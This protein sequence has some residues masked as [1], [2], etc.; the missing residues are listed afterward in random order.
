MLR[1]TLR[2]AAPGVLL[3]TV[4]LVPFLDKAFTIDDTTLMMMAEHAL[5]EPL[6]PSAIAIAWESDVPKRATGATGALMAWLLVPAAL[7]GGSERLAHGMEL[8][9]LAAGVLGTVALA[10]RL[11]LGP[12]PARA[13]GLLLVSTP[14]VLGLSGTA[15]PDVPAM[16]V[17][18][19]GLERLLAW[20]S[21]RRSSQGI[22]AALLLGLAP[23]LRPNLVLL[24]ALGALCWSE[25]WR[26]PRLGGPCR[27]GAGSFSQPSPLSRC[28]C[29]S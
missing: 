16:A 23:L 27:A 28:S 2:S 17:S 14:A 9:A 20:R 12:R 5:V 8:V 13:A 18:V 26:G 21:E 22:A 11:G 6:H 3:A 10:L 29:R 24:P 7:A 1:S 19:L 4:L 15:M 25:G